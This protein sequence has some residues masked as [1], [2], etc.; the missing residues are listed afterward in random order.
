L[1]RIAFGDQ[2]NDLRLLCT[3]LPVGFGE[4]RDGGILCALRVGSGCFGALLGGPSH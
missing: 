4:R 2:P 3:E 1:R